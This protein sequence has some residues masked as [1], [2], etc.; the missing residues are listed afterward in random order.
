MNMAVDSRL[1]WAW[2]GGQHGAYLGYGEED[3]GD[4]GL[5]IVGLLEDGDLLPKP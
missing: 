4:E 2:V 3:A 5:A 1:R